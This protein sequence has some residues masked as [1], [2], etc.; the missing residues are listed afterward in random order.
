MAIRNDGN[1]EAWLK[2]FL[3]GVG[4][5][6]RSATETARKILELRQKHQA[7]IRDKA[8]NQTNAA[9]LLDYLFEQPI[10]NVRLVE[11]HVKCAFVTADKLVKQFEE[12]GIVKEV[13]GGQR[14]RRY[15]YSPYL[16]LFEPSD[17]N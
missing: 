3:K 15:E 2:F 17:V 10:V 8:S 9:L 13:T 4:E 5:V 1:W 6:S 16:A 7:L 12:L 11:E 14:N